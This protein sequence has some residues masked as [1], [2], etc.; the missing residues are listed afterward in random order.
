MTNT[1]HRNDATFSQVSYSDLGGSTPA[2]PAF[3]VHKN[4]TNQT[5][6]PDA[7][8]TQITFSTELYDVG[9][10]FASSVWTPPAGVV[11]LSAAFVGD[12]VTTTAVPFAY[13]CIFKNGSDYRRGLSGPLSSSTSFGMISMD[14]TANGTDTYG[15][16]VFIPNA[17]G[18]S[19]I[20]GDTPLTWFTGHWI[21]P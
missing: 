10:H 7:A 3:S 17:G 1:F 18:T 4:G 11:H 15:V 9:N 6:I 12:A 14:D 13:L 16:Y 20:R 2:V 8:F 19:T 5:G 21:S